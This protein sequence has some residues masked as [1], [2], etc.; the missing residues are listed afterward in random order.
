MVGNGPNTSFVTS[1]DYL[2]KKMLVPLSK[3]EHYGSEMLSEA[4]RCKPRLS[5]MSM[6]V[7][8]V[9]AGAQYQPPGRFLAASNF[10]K[11]L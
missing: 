2:E 7:L 5:V 6:L 8:L 4:A 11:F 3:G 9:Q 1:I 10:V